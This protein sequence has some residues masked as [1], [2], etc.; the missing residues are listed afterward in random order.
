MALAIATLCCSPPDN[1]E[2]KCSKPGFS[3][4]NNMRSLFK[5]FYRTIRPVIPDKKNLNASLINDYL[6]S[7]GIAVR[8]LL[9][10]G[11]ENALRITLGTKEELNKTIEILKEFII[12]ND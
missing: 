7:K 2:G 5:W 8:Y 11:L 1:C 4:D 10:Y 12:N 6:L 9:S 3:Y